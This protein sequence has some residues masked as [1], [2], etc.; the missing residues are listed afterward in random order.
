[1]YYEQDFIF[2][3]SDWSNIVD[4]FSAQWFRFEILMIS[5]IL[6]ISAFLVFLPL[7]GFGQLILNIEEIRDKVNKE[8]NYWN[9][10]LGKN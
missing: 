7:Y 2:Y 9:S 8:W 10:Y 5:L 3:F 1:M 4:N 6:V